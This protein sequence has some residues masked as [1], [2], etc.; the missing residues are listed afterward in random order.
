MQASKIKIGS[1]Y[2][3]KIDEKLYR[4][5]VTSV[6][7]TRKGS[8]PSDFTHVIEGNLADPPKGLGAHYNAR[9]W[10][11]EEV[12]GEFTEYAELVQQKQDAETKAKAERDHLKARAEHLAFLLYKISGLERVGG[13]DRW[14]DPIVEDYHGLAVRRAAVEPLIAAIERLTAKQDA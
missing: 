9:K 12:L 1:S 7:T 6:T 14:H 2:A 5:A 10:S 11:P 8:H 3:V 4:L 13:R